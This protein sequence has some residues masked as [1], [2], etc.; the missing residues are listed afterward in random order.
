MSTSVIR[1]QPASS[2]TL[3]RL[4]IRHPLVAYFVIAFGGT[5]IFFLP[6]VLSRGVNGLGILPFTLPDIALFAVFILGTLAGPALASISVTAATSGK[7]GVGHLLRR[8]VQWRVSVGWYLIAIFGFFLIYFVGYSVFLRVNLLLALLAHWTLLLTVFLPQTVFIILTGAFAEE[9]GWRG[10]ALPRLQ[11]RYGPV[12]ATIILGTLHG[13]WH[14]PAFFT[15]LLGPFNL[16]YYVGFL[17]T[18]MAATFLFTWIFNHTQG[19]VLLAT[20]THGC[21]DGIQN[22]IVLLI[23]ANLVVSGWTAPIANGNW[24]GINVITFGICAILLLVFTRGRLG[25][26]PERNAQLIVEAQPA[27]MSHA[28]I[29]E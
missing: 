9:L 1:M 15:R 22:V 11:Q 5:W 28:P 3:K 21:G 4:I 16:I 8:C 27:E 29:E 6:F 12:L 17:F 25:Y 24:N 18:A 13:L 19:S 20:L 2:S 23:P 7:V 26:H 14:L 10:F